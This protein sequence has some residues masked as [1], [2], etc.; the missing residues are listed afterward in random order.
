M[1]HADR[2]FK[3]RGMA[4]LR[5]VEDVSHDEAQNPLYNVFA[6]SLR[7]LCILFDLIALACIVAGFWKPHCFVL[8]FG[9]LLLVGMNRSTISEIQ[10]RNGHA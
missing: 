5:R 2:I 4:N 1:N 6:L 9:F 8:A 3:H 10:G 7:V